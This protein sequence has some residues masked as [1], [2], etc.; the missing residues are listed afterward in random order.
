MRIK[1]TI[2]I[3]TDQLEYF[4]EMAATAERKG[5]EY[6]AFFIDE[7]AWR[8]EAA[9]EIAL[10]VCDAWHEQKDKEV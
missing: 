7:E 9:V 1:L 2:E 10:A 6:L 5:A 4:E 3:D 8:D